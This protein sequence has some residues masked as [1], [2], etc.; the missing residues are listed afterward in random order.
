MV[1]SGLPPGTRVRLPRYKHPDASQIGTIV[2]ELPESG[3][4]MVRV[5]YPPNAG[6]A[7]VVGY[8]DCGFTYEELLHYRAPP[9]PTP[10]G[11]FDRTDEQWRDAD[12]TDLERGGYNDEAAWFPSTLGKW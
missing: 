5:A 2:S 7:E 9:K 6:E 8:Q 10:P 4:Y 12:P 11:P 1:P 3:G